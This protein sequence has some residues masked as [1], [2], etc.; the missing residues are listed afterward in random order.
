MV[1]TVVMIAGFKRV[2]QLA[3]LIGRQQRSTHHH[4]MLRAVHVAERQI[5]HLIDDLN[6][7]L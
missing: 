6:G 3:I 2:F 1:V 5:H 4:M 7:V